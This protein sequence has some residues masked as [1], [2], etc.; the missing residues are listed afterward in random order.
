MPCSLVEKMVK[1]KKS[2]CNIADEER[3]FLKY[4]QIKI[5]KATSKLRTRVS[6]N[7]HWVKIF[8]PHL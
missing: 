3:K 7:Y 1:R 6:F 8:V 2:H 4:V 5:E